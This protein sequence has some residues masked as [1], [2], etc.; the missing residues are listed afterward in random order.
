V[1]FERQFDLVK[2]RHLVALGPFAS[3]MLTGNHKGRLRGTVHTYRGVP[4]ICTHHPIDILKDESGV[5]KSET[6]YDLKLLL[7][8]MGRSGREGK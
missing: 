2:P 1:F 5:K 7:E 4:L 3:R 8:V 6:G